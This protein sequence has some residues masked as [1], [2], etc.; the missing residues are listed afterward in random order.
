MLEEEIA[1]LG[2]ALER[3]GV[4]LTLELAFA[5]QPPRERNQR[6]GVGIFPLLNRRR[7]QRLLFLWLRLELKIDREELLRCLR[8]RV[9]LETADE[10]CWLEAVIG[11]W[12]LV[13]G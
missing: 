9:R 4:E 2:G 1:R 11:Y 7:D 6:I 8:K 5:V 13:I 3:N 12:F 10:L